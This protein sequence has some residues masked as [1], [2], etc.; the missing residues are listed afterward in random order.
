[1]DSVFF[2]VFFIL[3]LAPSNIFGAVDVEITNTGHVVVQVLDLFSFFKPLF[4][5]CKLINHDLSLSM[6]SYYDV[7]PSDKLC[8]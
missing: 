5:T 3:A 7:S 6:F 1:M 8:T 2:V 4:L